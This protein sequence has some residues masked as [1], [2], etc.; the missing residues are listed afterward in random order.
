MAG[1]G[2]RGMGLQHMWPCPAR[3]AW[4][5]AYIP[6]EPLQSPQPVPES[7]SQGL[8]LG[9]ENLLDLPGGEDGRAWVLTP[10]RGSP[11]SQV[12]YVCTVAR[13][14]CR[15]DPSWDFAWKW[16]SLGSSLPSLSSLLTSFSWHSLLNPHLRSVSR[17]PELRPTEGE[18]LKGKGG[19]DLIHPLPTLCQAQTTPAG[20]KYYEVHD[21]PH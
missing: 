19:P 6:S 12:R 4:Y 9:R 18:L 1:S 21:I 16:P 7:L 20:W 3:Q 15:T 8:C 10:T 17:K 2:G 14:P 5:S 13:K 11:S